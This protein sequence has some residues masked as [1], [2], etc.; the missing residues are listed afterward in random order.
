LDSHQTNKFLS[1]SCPKALIPVLVLVT[2]LDAY[3]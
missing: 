3:K 2:L 1:R